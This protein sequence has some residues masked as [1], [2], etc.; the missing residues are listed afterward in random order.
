[1]LEGSHSVGITVIVLNV[2]SEKVALEE[3]KSFLKGLLHFRR[4]QAVNSRPVGVKWLL[5]VVRSKFR[6]KLT[7]KVE[8]HS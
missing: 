8:F 5:L 7:S 6:R 3:L 4:H 1:M 2:T